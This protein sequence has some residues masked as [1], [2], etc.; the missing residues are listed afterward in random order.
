MTEEKKPTEVVSPEQKDAG[1]TNTTTP[2][3]TIPV[4]LYGV[5][6]DLPLSKAKELITKRDTKTKEYNELK[7]KIEVAESKAKQEAERASLLELM[8]KNSVEEVEAAVSQKYKDTISRFEKKVFAGEIQSNLAKLGVLPEAIGDATKL[9]MADATPTLEGEEVKL[10]GKKTE[11]YLAEWVK[12]KTHLLSV[13]AGDGG[14]KK[15]GKTDITPP[16]QEKSRSEA[17]KSGLGSFIK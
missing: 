16:R 15:V 12:T 2:E 5:T 6:V 1:A 7:G 11:E 13:K 9:V 4:D 8:K 14:K 17:L 3:K 10:A